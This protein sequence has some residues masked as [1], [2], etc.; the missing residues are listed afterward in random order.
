[1]AAARWRGHRANGLCLEPRCAGLDPWRD[2]YPCRAGGVGAGVS[3]GGAALRGEGIRSAGGIRG[4]S[5]AEWSEALPPLRRLRDR[6]RAG[7]AHALRRAASFHHLRC[8]NSHARRAYAQGQPRCGASSDPC[9]PHTQDNARTP[10]GRMRAGGWAG[11]GNGARWGRGAS[12]TARSAG[13][14]G[15]ISEERRFE[16]G[17]AKKWF[18]SDIVKELRS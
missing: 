4:A 11:G 18:E 17:V 9:A 14:A 12:P 2:L 5:G 13:G 8:P 3:L 1:M 16:D 6:R 15:R 10:A 7:P